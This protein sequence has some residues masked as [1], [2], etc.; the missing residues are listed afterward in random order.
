MLENNKCE[1]CR[2]GAPKVTEDEKKNFLQELQNWTVVDDGIEKLVKDFKFSSYL[3]AVEFT[4]K[5]A[6]M[7]DKEDHHPKIVLE[8]G[9]VT[10]FWWS[11]AIKG[12]HK[13]DFICAAKTDSLA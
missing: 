11:H 4:K 1:A 10:V 5:V 12:L 6:E 7:A 2:V 8:W 13:N 3:Q 9:L